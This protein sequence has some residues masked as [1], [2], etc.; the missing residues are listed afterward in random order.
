MTDRTTLALAACQGLDDAE[1]AQRGAGGYQ[2]MR[3]RKRHYASLARAASIGL[4]MAAKQMKEQQAKIAQ[5]E[6][7]IAELQNLD[8]PITD[9]SE[10]ANLLAGLNK[11][12]AS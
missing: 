3:D 4:K 6:A 10:A 7:T 9:T 12:D 11:K 5:L 2:K 1:L 8:A